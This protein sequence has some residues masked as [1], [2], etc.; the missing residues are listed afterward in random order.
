MEKIGEIEILGMKCVIL[1]DAHIYTEL[2]WIIWG[3]CLITK[4]SPDGKTALEVVVEEAVYNDYLEKWD[5]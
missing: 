3:S 5:G 1:K 4:Y 2:D